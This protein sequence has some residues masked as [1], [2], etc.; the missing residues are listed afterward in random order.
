MRKKSESEGDDDEES[1]SEIFKS[2]SAIQTKLA[3]KGG[4]SRTN[5]KGMP[6]SAASP[7]QQ[8]QQQGWHQEG[9]VEDVRCGR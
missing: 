5:I 3:S 6:P 1:I 8:Q 7:S 4:R 2:L 9:I